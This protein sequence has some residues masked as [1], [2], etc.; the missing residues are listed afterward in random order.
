MVNCMTAKL[1]TAKDIFL[2]LV[3]SVAPD[4]WDGRLAELCLGDVQLERRVQALL[5][6]HAEPASFLEQPA[7]GDI[8]SDSDAPTICEGPGT[9]IGPYKLLEAIGEGGMGVVFRAEQ[10]QPVHRTVALKIIKP[11]MD[12]RQV[13]ARFEAERQAL[14]MMDH[15]NIARVLDAGTIGAG[16]MEQ[17]AESPAESL[18]HAPCST[19]TASSRPYF[20]MELVKGI[21]I[22][23]YCD[24]KQLSIPMRL[25]LFVAVCQGVQHAHQKGIIHRDLKPSNVLVA[26]YD[27]QPV[28]KIIDFGVAKAI[29]PQLTDRTLF[30]RFGQ[31]IGTF[32]YMSPEQSRFNQL[33]IDTRS[34]IYSLGVLLYELLTGTT[35]FEKQ[36]LETLAFDE[37]LRIIRE[38]EPPRPSARLSAS[39]SVPLIAAKFETEPAR[40]SR[41]LHGDLDWIVMKCL[42][43]D[44]NR[45][46]ETAGALATDIKHFLNDEPVIARPPSGLYRAGKFVRRN[47]AVAFASAAVL[48]GLIA[49]IVGVS[50]GLVSQS[51]QRVIAER[52]RAEA[53]LN[54]AI[55]LQSQR[56]YAEAEDLYRQGLES[57]RGG[58]P[59]ERQKAARTRLRLAQVVADRSGAAQ[60]EQLHRE[61]L[62]AYRAAFPPGNPN[63]AHALFDLAIVLRTQ[64]R[65]AEAEPLFREV[66]EIHRR[67]IPADHRAIGESAAILS[68]VL[69]RLGRFVE[70]EPLAREAVAEHLLAV[71]HD[72]WALAH[73]RLELGRDLLSLG[74]FSEAEAVLLDAHRELLSTDSVHVGPLA[75]TA[76]YTA[77]DRAEPGKG[78]DVKVR[79][80]LSNLIVTF[81]RL[82]AIAVANDEA[83]RTLQPQSSSEKLPDD[84]KALESQ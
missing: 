39:Q 26:K 69:H 33:D 56:K 30:T 59:L 44:R 1:R 19:L 24:A 57:S 9:L 32:E 81:V 82:D 64:Q 67:A 23:E 8:P 84:D 68:N 40:L 17:G 80:W 14:A 5:Q 21:P 12:S 75:L 76:L 55:S 63:I 37:T 58:T 22:N 48:L 6:A 78:Y 41:Q 52:E 62:H 83:D 11:G 28:P 36:R 77:W 34:D 29:D 71:P 42:E 4:Q 2:E 72:E 10:T 16:S 47:K 13:I 45:R 15:A 18:L 60:S 31:I 20:V 53:Q 25:E 70:A 79:E 50:I 61:A 35:P 54:L 73:A 46:Y 38:E 74:R 49:G 66:Y 3:G 7:L 27:G 43:K 65:F 51:R